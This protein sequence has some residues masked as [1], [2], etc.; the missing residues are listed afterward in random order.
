VTPVLVQLLLY[1]TAAAYFAACGLFL[2]YLTGHGKAA[3]AQRLA[4]ALVGLGAVLHATHI[5]LSSLVLN[6]CPIK[7]IH[8]ALSVV[9]MLACATY[10]VVRTRYKIDAVGVIVAP[11]A[12]TF[13]VGSQAAHADASAAGRVKSAV[14]PIHILANLFGEALFVLAFAAAVAYLFAEKQL[15]KKKVGGVLQRL[16]PLDVLDRAEHAFLLAGFP[17]LTVGII[18]GAV[19]AERVESGSMADLWRS[20]FGYATWTLF[21]AV[22][23]LRAARGW[24]GRRA[25]YG[26][27]AGFAFAVV[28]LV[29]YLVRSFGESPSAPHANASAGETGAALTQGE[30][31]L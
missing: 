29:I 28:V 17:M 2:F 5:V 31:T 21:A 3:T 26:T 8:F 20:L 25:A 30:R 23:L 13:L 24:R 12:L 27:I 14:L 10:V 1:A 22:L 7:G 4:V 16:P 6:I 18:T 15:K 19:W 11:L 9:S